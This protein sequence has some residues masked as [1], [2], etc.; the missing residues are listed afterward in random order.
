MKKELL[1]T[2]LLLLGLSFK[3]FA[4]TGRVTDGIE[5]FL[6]IVGLLVIVLVLLN[7]A[8]YLRKNGKTIIYNIRLFLNRKI[9][10]VRNY[11]NKMKT[12]YI[13]IANSKFYGYVFNKKSRLFRIGFW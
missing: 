6:F 1:I 13:V 7:G 3:S 5:F 12:D 4:G 2:I 9:T 11:H 10:S 8:D